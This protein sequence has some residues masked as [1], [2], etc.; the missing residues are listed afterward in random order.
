MAFVPEFDYV[1]AYEIPAKVTSIEWLNRT[2]SQS[3]MSFVVANDKKIR[4]FKLRKEFIDYFK[5]GNLQDG[6]GHEDY[7]ESSFVER[8]IQ[9]NGQI[10]FPKTRAH[11]ELQ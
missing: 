6:D 9:S 2:S 5:G 10:V 8:Y 11:A 7:N 4:L 3:T 1:R